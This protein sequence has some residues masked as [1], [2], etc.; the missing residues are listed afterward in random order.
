MKLLEKLQREYTNSVP[1]IDQNETRR[2][3]L[4]KIVAGSAA[5]AT[6]LFVSNRA[7]ACL[8]CNNCNPGAGNYCVVPLGLCWDGQ[9]Y[10][11]QYDVYPGYPHEHCCTDIQGPRECTNMC[12][13]IALC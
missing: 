3:V 8:G 11:Y 13:P 10:I 7:Y 2:S 9:V 4:R 6:G 12:S 5:F 1:A